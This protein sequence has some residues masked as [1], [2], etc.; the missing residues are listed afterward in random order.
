MTIDLVK[1][2][3]GQ[4][5]LCGFHG[6]TPS[7]E[8]T[9]LIQKYNVG[10]IILFSRNIESAEQVKAL[11]QDLQRIAKE[12]GHTRPLLIAVDQENG[13][14]RRLGKSGAYFPGSMAL[15][16]LGSSLVAGQVA[17]ATAREL[18]ALGINWNLAPVADVNNN[19]L[20]PVIGVRSF[21]EN[22]QSVGSLATAQVE[23]YHR[24]GLATAIKHFPGHGD[25]ATDSHLSVPVIHKTLQELEQVEL[26]PFRQAMASQGDAYPSAVMVGHMVLP[27]ITDKI[28]CLSAEVVQGLLRHRL[29]YRGVVVTDCLEMDAV[30]DTV[31]VPKAAIL[32]LQAGVDVLDISH[33]YEHQKAALDAIYQAWD[34]QDLLPAT[35][36]AS[37]DRVAQLKDRFLSWDTLCTDA[38]ERDEH[39]SLS[40]ALYDR[41]P[42]VVRNRTQII[43]LKTKP[44]ILFLAAH[45]PMTLAIDTDEDPFKPMYES[46]RKR[47]NVR[48]VVF[49]K[50]TPDM[51][52]QI[53]KAGYVVIGT[54]NANLHPFQ[55][56][57]V[58]LAHQLSAKLVVMAILNPYDLMAFPEIDTYVVSYE[59]S[60]PALEASV[61]TIFG[62]I[63]PHSRLPVTIPGTE[64]TPKAVLVEDYVDGDLEEVTQI[65][66][67]NFD[68]ELRLSDQKVRQ[69]LTQALRPKHFV[70]RS[71]GKVLGFGATQIERDEAS[72]VVGEL[73]LLMV[74]PSAQGQGIGTIL[75]EHVL[76]YFRQAGVDRLM[77]GSTYPRFFPGVPQDQTAAQD[78]FKR[79]GWRLDSGVV[80]DLIGDLEQY[81]TPAA[82]KE[83]VAKEKVWFG[84]IRPDSIWEL[85]GFV[86]HYFPYW[87][88]TYK[89]HA[90]LGD[91]QDLIVAREGDEHGPI[92]ASLVLHTTNLSH[93]KRCDL[94]WTLPG[95]TSPKSG[96]LACVG[97]ATEQ[98]GRGLGLGI[99]AYGNET[100]K[101]RG[102][103]KSYVDWVEWVEFYRRTGYQT[104]RGYHLSL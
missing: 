10:G 78:F 69:V 51:S 29:R 17:H 45:V 19:P 40:E 11:T 28:A 39:L 44:D 7:W 75:H 101:R 18:R 74:H 5:L 58:R 95:L 98:R 83:R 90:E 59:C 56:D 34:S 71:E 12:A 24:S 36:K 84:R 47:G 85:Y 66:N 42:T 37:L 88:S 1:Q 70:V 35:I 93:E 30:K 9:E 3:L 104:W 52:D 94:I 2:T 72:K 102:V 46:L 22:P 8:I 87:L 54:A 16:A 6:M 15:G 103:L 41:I 55:V 97:V 61:R 91:F 26:V 92:V 76:D 23:A 48:Y 77:L 25:T 50:G 53:R 33:T 63:T 21:G 31:G 81:E 64:H 73:M 13:V 99:V 67:E 27:K 100:L 20:N 65:W 80:W 14:V 32:A 49:D 82:I 62:E 60:P 38:I 86:Q 57:M 96:G 43:P 79:R 4:L 68:D 89:H